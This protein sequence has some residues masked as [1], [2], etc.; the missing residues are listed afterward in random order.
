MN[1]LVKT[2]EI[3][4]IDPRDVFH[5]INFIR[6]FLTWKREEKEKKG[7]SPYA[8]WIAPSVILV[9]IYRYS[10]TPLEEG[11]KIN[12]RHEDIVKLE[13]LSYFRPHRFPRVDDAW[14]RIYGGEDGEVIRPTFLGISFRNL[15][16]SY[17][18]YFER[19]SIDI[20]WFERDFEVLNRVKGRVFPKHLDFTESKTVESML[21]LENGLLTI[22][23]FLYALYTGKYSG[24]GDGHEL[25]Y[26]FFLPF[27]ETFQSYG[28]TFEEA[29]SVAK[30]VSMFVG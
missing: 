22:M 11:L 24:F 12:F 10:Q 9:P 27:T 16:Y 23:S 30:E 29:L 20:E 28:E 14:F 3:I 19:D 17:G 21:H 2:N 1:S 4:K 6:N 15:S 26:E 25:E 13:N 7:L 18:V 5:F 8:Y